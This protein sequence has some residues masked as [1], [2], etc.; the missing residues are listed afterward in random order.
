MRTRAPVRIGNGAFN[1]RQNDVW[2][3]LLDSIY[4]HAKALG[5]PRTRRGS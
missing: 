3:A 4:L 1:Q 5:E 2:G